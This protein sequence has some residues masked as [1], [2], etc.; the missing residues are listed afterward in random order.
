[1]ITKYEF[2]GIAPGP[3]LLLLGAV[4]GDEVCGTIAINRI[5]DDINTGRLTINAGRMIFV[6]ICNERAYAAGTRFADENLNRVMRTYENPTTYEQRAANEIVP[7]IQSADFVL[8]I[9]SQHV[10]GEPFCFANDMDDMRLMDFIRATGA[11]FVITGWDDLYDASTDSSTE[12]CAARAGVIATTLECGGH[13]APQSPIVAYNAAL[14]VMQH[15][16]IIDSTPIAKNLTRIHMTEVYYFNGG[17]LARDWRTFD[18]V[19]TGD[20]IALDARGTEI[21]APVDGCIVLPNPNAK[22][23]EEW[24]YIAK[25]FP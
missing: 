18:I 4:H 12:D 19:R 14:G 22:M 17:R 9:H 1:M 25:P 11:P 8:D 5:V 20:V 21:I 10:D 2:A 16:G 13:D 6:P 3:T 23:G 15:L 24:F 7:L